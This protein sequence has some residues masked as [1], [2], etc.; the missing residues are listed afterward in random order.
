MFGISR[1][2]LLNIVS[3]AGFAV[4]IVILAY[5]SFV[6]GVVARESYVIQVAMPEAGGV[7]PLQEVT[8]MGHA[9]GQVTDVEVTTDGVVIFMKINGTENV[10]SEGIVRVLRRS[11]IGEQ[12]V[13]IEPTGSGWT[14]AAKT[15]D[16]KQSAVVIEATERIVPSEVPALL[17]NTARLFEAFETDDIS[18][19]ISEAADAFGDRGDDFRMLGRDLLDL[20]TTLVDGIPEFDR[21]ITSSDVVLRT[22]HEHRVALGQSITN[23]AD[24]TETLADDRPQFDAVLDNVDPM[25]TQLDALIR[26][27]R[28]N[29]QCLA[30]DLR[31]LNTSLLAPNQFDTKYSY[32][33]YSHLADTPTLGSTDPY[34]LKERYPTILDAVEAVLEGH[35][36]FFQD[37][38]GLL[39]EPDTRTGLGW[40]RVAFILSTPDQEGDTYA[41]SRITPNSRPGAAC[42]SQSFGTG[43][44]AIPDGGE[45]LP[46]TMER[47]DFAPQV[48]ATG[49]DPIDP[50]PRADGGLPLPATG[51]GIL[52]VALL[53][54]GAA[55]MLRRRA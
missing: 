55:A 37:G 27:E 52:L 4:L 41:H 31:T 46:P 16:G 29:L 28:A 19:I 36:S 7:L 5:L 20:Q 18:T 54:V 22:L 23:A 11:P 1:R 25:L 14:P 26:N 6:T 48:V 33:D 44:N 15:G 2:V 35:R 42:I 17:E 50:P 21:F 8:V 40:P 47:R 34:N 49:G 38:F 30:T 9:V 45:P 3:M 53:T 43:V 39:I 12:A 32:V 10:P 24:L 51:G 13:D